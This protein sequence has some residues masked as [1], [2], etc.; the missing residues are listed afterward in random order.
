MTARKSISKRIRFEVFKRDAFTCQYCGK[1]APDVVLHIDHIKP[2]S[3]GGS[4]GILNLVTSCESCNSGKSNI[5]LSDSSAVKKQQSQLMLMA[6][7]HEQIK[8]MI[9]W[10]DSIANSEDLL[11]ESVSNLVEKLLV[12]KYPSDS[13][14]MIIRK[15]IRKHGYQRV[16]DSVNEAYESS[17]DIDAFSRKWSNHVAYADVKQEDASKKANY[18]KGIL[19]NRFS[20]F[21]DVRFYIEIKSLALGLAELDQLL[22]I[23]KECVTV[24]QFYEQAWRLA[25]GQI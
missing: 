19:R 18:I 11:V 15:S 17:Y 5:E 13:G 7:K 8:L 2:V 1:V 20:S 25:N 16:I 23:S 9:K 3:K 12:N 24:T 14:R 6:E 21:N 4:N 10:R 22:E